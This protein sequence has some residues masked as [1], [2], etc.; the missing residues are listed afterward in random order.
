M[1]DQKSKSEFEKIVKEK[2]G[3]LEN[4][5]NISSGKLEEAVKLDSFDKE[6]YGICKHLTN[7]GLPTVLCC[8]GHGRRQAYVKFDSHV[9]ISQVKERISEEKGVSISLNHHN[10]GFDYVE[11]QFSFTKEIEKYLV[12]V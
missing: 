11:I 7:I 12:E 6:M 3:S 1:V 5:F 8:S 4:F 9:L 2:F 10:W